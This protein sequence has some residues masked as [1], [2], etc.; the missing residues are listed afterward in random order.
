MANSTTNKHI[1][2]NMTAYDVMFKAWEMSNMIHD[3]YEAKHFLLDPPQ[4]VEVS[5]ELAIRLDDLVNQ[6]YIEGTNLTR[7]LRFTNSRSLIVQKVTRAP[8]S[9]LYFGC[10]SVNREMTKRELP[11][12]V[13]SIRNNTLFHQNFAKEIERVR[14]IL[15]ENPHLSYDFQALIDTEGNLF[16]IDV[17]GYI[18]FAHGPL[19][20]FKRCR[21]ECLHSLEKVLNAANQSM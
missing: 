1:P 20:W 14:I 18:R 9:V 5:D 11:K 13:P 12:F 7:G 3:K 19:K 6:P 21:G 16:H 4:Q 15:S 8:S 10:A 17:E 2:Q